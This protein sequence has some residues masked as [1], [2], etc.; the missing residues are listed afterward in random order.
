MKQRIT[1]G[2][3]QQ[4]TP[5]QQEKLRELWQPQFGNILE[6]KKH[7]EQVFIYNEGDSLYFDEDGYKC[8][9]KENCL[10]LLSIGQMI[11]LLQEKDALGSCVYLDGSSIIEYVDICDRL[12]QAVKEIL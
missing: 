10:P 2:Q 7:G 4:L 1:S 5:F 9:T 12:F 6:S 8:D 11:E 3:L